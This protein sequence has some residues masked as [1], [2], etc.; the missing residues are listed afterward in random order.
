[1]SLLH[2]RQVACTPPRTCRGSG[3]S[4]STFAEN[5]GYGFFLQARLQ[6][7]GVLWG[8]H[9]S[10]QRCVAMQQSVGSAGPGNKSPLKHRSTWSRARTARLKMLAQLLLLIH[11]H[12]LSVPHGQG[13]VLLVGAI[14][15]SCGRLVA[16]I[17]IPIVKPLRS[18]GLVILVFR[19]ACMR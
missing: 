12:N 8:V 10:S 18:L 13:I 15:P 4:P 11:N 16:V 1:M 14:K 7:G 5:V 6:L 19:G 3:C 9:D 17:I 2:P